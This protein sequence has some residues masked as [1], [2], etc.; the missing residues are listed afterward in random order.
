M[1]VLLYS[2]IRYLIFTTQ[3]YFLLIIFNVDIT[4]FNSMIIIMTMLL[5]VSIVPTIFITEI[6]VRASIAVMLFSLITSNSF[7]VISA[8]FLLWVVNLLLP[9]L[10][11]TFFV[12]SLR[13]FRK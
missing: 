10:V 2:V 7:G 1:K 3:F 4:Y 9:A 5:V 8:T 12:F 11:G 13:F 6:G